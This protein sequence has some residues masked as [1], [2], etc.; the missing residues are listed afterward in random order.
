MISFDEQ[1]DIADLEDD[2]DDFKPCQVGK[3]TSSFYANINA[4]FIGLVG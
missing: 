4:I 2:D 3:I 1:T